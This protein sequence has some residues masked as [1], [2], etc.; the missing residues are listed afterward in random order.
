MVFV[1]L[2]Y[3]SN[4]RMGHSLIILDDND[5]ENRLHVKQKTAQ[6][7]L[8]AEWIFDNHLTA[9]TQFSMVCSSYSIIFNLTVVES[10][11][12]TDDIIFF[13]RQQTRLPARVPWR[14]RSQLQRYKMTGV[15]GNILLVLD[16]TDNAYVVIKVRNYFAAIQFAIICNLDVNCYCSQGVLKSSNPIDRSETCVLPTDVPHMVKLFAL[17]ETDTTVFFVLEHVRCLIVTSV[18][19]R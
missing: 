12:P 16:V 19:L 10:P 9:R 17:H 2:L 5:V 3:E 13:P 18:F 7:L 6:Y 4:A 8:R 15:F 1:L 11:S 14:S